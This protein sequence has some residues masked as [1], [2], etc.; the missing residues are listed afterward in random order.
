MRVEFALV[1][2]GPSDQALV[3]P[4]EDLCV[5]CGASE[6]I[7]EAPDLR[8]LPFT[9]GRRVAD[10]L[11]AVVELSP[12]MDLYLI[13]R[14]ADARD[15]GPRYAE[16]RRAVGHVDAELRWIGVVPVQET[17]AWAMLDEAEIR[18]VA[19]NPRGT[20]GLGLPRRPARVEAVAD[21]KRKIDDAIV[22]AS[23]L[24]GRRLSKF[25]RSL[26]WRRALLLQRID[27]SGPIH[28][29]PAWRRLRNDLRS[30]ISLL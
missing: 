2:E 25:R 21:P 10:K 3:R 23:G 22:R 27:V 29:V 15:P 28:H 1:A 5:E 8:R 30:A 4:L 24:S 6:A 19:E 7:G 12:E 13:H 16:M 26:P 14:D 9:V 11:R 17:E 20:M 18:R